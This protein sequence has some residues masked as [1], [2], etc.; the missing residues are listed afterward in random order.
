MKA[1]SFLGV[2]LLISTA[3]AGAGD[4]KWAIHEW[5]TFTSL[6][7]ENGEAIG[8]INT[9]D[10]P[11]PE[12]VHR[13][14]DPLVLQPTEIPASFCKGVP[15]CHPDVTMRLETPVIYFHP[16]A[17]WNPR[18]VDVHVAFNGGWL[19]EFYP[20]ADFRD[21]GFESEQR[22]GHIRKDAAGELSWKGLAIGTDARGPETKERVWLAPRAVDAAPVTT[23]R[24]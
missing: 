16:P 1:I 19:T 18:P 17:G 12:F 6:Q 4:N 8:G 10:E 23:D 22:I 2:A 7:N 21:P 9:D 24:K 13:L 15:H 14:A 11:V 5:G 20:N 3:Q